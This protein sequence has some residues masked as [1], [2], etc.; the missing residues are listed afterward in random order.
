[1][2][3]LKVSL[4]L[5]SHFDIK[6]SFKCFLLCNYPLCFFSL[7]TLLRLSMAKLKISLCR[8]HFTLENKW[9]TFKY[10]LILI[11][12]IIPQWWENRFCM[13][14]IPLNQEMFAPC[15]MSLDMFQCLLVYSLWELEQNLY[16]TIV[17]KL[18]KY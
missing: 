1:M 7:L 10:L 5:I 15:F 16:P 11:Y 6:F 13:I 4:I 3:F 17:W 8:C 12:N 14:S 9:V 2:G 18:Y